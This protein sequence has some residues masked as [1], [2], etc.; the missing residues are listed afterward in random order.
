LSGKAAFLALRRN[1][2]YV[3][4][5]NL[6]EIKKAELDYVAGEVDKNGGLARVFGSIPEEYTTKAFD[7]FVA[8]LNSGQYTS[9]IGPDGFK[10]EFTPVEIASMKATT[11]L[12]FE[13]LKLALVKQELAVL[14]GG[15]PAQ[16]KGAPPRPPGASV[17][18][19]K[20]AEHEMNYQL[21]TLLEKK[22]YE[23]VL[24]AEEGKDVVVEVEVPAVSEST[25]PAKDKAAAP[26]EP[27]P[28][29]APVPGAPAKTKKITLVLPKFIYPLAVRVAA[30]GLL[31]EIRSEAPDW[32]LV[33]RGRAQK[34]VRDAF[35]KMLGGSAIEKF[36]LEELPRPVARW[37]LD[38][39]M[40]VG[41]LGTSSS[42]SV[43]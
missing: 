37:L 2:S 36:K 39:R 23:Y 43:F 42:V 17:D 29:P 19:D 32:A 41:T 7:K 8:L 33:E 12:F 13:K 15:S 1:Y 18:G 21:A 26:E 11:R 38:N 20:L 30:A 34:K 24:S 4:N 40:V 28:A 3:G 10:F 14:S 31:R 5:L 22:L 6:E 27:K 25:A 35:G 9:G 16:V